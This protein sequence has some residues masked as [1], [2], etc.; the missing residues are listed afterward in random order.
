M[1]IS[2]LDNY[3]LKVS[4]FLVCAGLL[5]LKAR[6]KASKENWCTF[7]NSYRMTDGVYLL[8]YI[9]TK[10]IPF[11]LVNP[12]SKDLFNYFCVMNNP[13]ENCN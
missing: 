8:R 3:K 12:I 7:D 13:C 4:A 11:L 6:W 5:Q 10:V 2:L 1:T 9:V